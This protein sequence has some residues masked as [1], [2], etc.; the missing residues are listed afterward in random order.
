MLR[1]YP[2]RQKVCSKVVP[3]NRYAAGK[4]GSGGLLPEKVFEE[5]PPEP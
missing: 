4:W 3:F 1:I 5:T 2:N